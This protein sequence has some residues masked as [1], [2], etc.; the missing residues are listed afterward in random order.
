MDHNDNRI[1]RLLSRREVVRLVG[2][3]GAILLM[4]G[5][6]SPG[7][8]ASTGRESPC[9]VRPKQMEGPYF[10]DEQLYRSNIRP[11][12]STGRITPGI[13]LT[14]L[15]RVMNVRTEDCRPL[16]GAVVDIWHCDGMGFYSDVQDPGFNTKGQK[17]LRGYQVT[18]TQGEVRFVTI[19]PGWYPGR[20]VHIHVKIRTAPLQ[21]RSYDFTSQLYFDDALTDH[22]HTNPPYASRG[23]RTVRNHHDWI[24]RQGGN[25]LLLDP[26]PTA[27]G[28]T[29]VFSLGLNLP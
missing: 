14:L 7:L 20:T 18:D 23:P 11:D 3:T 8:A 28:Y 1:G 10:I 24:F 6:L 26:A 16:S 2:A 25:R 4:G 17:F 5:G 27:G 22:V 12:P 19:Y 9:M 13:P 15:L 29:A 21:G